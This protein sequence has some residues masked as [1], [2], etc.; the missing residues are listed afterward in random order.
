[1]TA[2]EIIT[3][4]LVAKRQE[5]ISEWVDLLKKVGGL[6]TGRINESELTVQCHDFLGL[7][8]DA[9][10]KGGVDVANPAYTQVRDFLGSPSRSR[11]LQGFHPER[12]R[13]SYFR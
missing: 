2:I 12:P 5:I 9:V 4:L 13:Y 10:A 7:F 11:A 8:G 3:K 1:M 6:E